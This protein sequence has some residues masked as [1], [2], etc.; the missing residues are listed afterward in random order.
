MKTLKQLANN[1]VV[2]CDNISYGLYEYEF[3]SYGTL[4]ARYRTTRGIN[5]NNKD[6]LQLTEYY[7]YSR[8]TSKYLKIFL[9]EYCGLWYDNTKELRKY[10]K[11]GGCDNVTIKVI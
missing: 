10:I 11:N 6:T 4:I 1:Q 7:D 8:T 5:E 9:N 3:Y 2:I